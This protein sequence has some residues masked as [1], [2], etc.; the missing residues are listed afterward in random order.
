MDFETHK[1]YAKLIDPEEEDKKDSSIIVVDTDTPGTIQ[2]QVGGS[3][4]PPPIDL[5]LDGE[6]DYAELEESSRMKLQTAFDSIPGLVNLGD[7][8]SQQQQP[9]PFVP[10]SE[11]QLF[12]DQLSIVKASNDKEA[13]L[14]ALEEL[15]DLA[16]DMDFGLLLSTGEGLK[17]LTDRLQYGS[18][19][20]TEHDDTR[21]VRFKAALVIGTAVQVNHLFATEHAVM[22]ERRQD[23]ISDPPPFLT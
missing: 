6:P 22:L 13:I 18:K 9:K 7:S 4:M 1:K 10:N 21:L 19:T 23:E 5:R 17:T 8:N 2:H 15:Q 20:D 14:G 11:H 12:L 16:S 3:N